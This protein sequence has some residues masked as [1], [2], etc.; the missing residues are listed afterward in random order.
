[1]DLG[2]VGH[3]VLCKDTLNLVEVPVRDSWHVLHVLRWAPRVPI[4]TIW[5]SNAKAKSII[6]TLAIH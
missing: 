2:V 5:P 1:M 4:L 3:M 6:E